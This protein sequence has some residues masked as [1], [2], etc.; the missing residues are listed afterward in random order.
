MGEEATGLPALRGPLMASLCGCGSSLTGEPKF[1]PRLC[2]LMRTDSLF[3]LESIVPTLYWYKL[4]LSMGQPGGVR[5]LPVQAE[6]RSKLNSR[7]L[8]AMSSEEE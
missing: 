3:G 6:Q 7:A 8:K 2:I 4:R 1:S 5:M